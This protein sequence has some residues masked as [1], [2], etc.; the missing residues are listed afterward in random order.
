VWDSEKAFP[1]YEQMKERYL[2][3]AKEGKENEY[4]WEG[5][6]HLLEGVPRAFPSR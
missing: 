3:Y 4:L 6:L 1:M 5:V 2:A